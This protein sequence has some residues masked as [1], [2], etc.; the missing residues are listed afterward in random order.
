MSSGS[1]Y[2]AKLLHECE[3]NRQRGGRNGRQAGTLGGLIRAVLRGTP[4]RLSDALDVSQKRI[5]GCS[6]LLVKLV[7]ARRVAAISWVSWLDVSRELTRLLSTA[8]YPIILGH[9][10]RLLSYR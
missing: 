1:A 6:L 4:K 2:G 8:I 5:E 7:L 3:S 10:V 9:E